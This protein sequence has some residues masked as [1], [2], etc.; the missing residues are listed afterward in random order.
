MLASPVSIR[1]AALWAAIGQSVVLL[2]TIG[3]LFVFTSAF[4]AGVHPTTQSTILTV[5]RILAAAGLFGFYYFLWTDEGRLPGGPRCRL[6]ARVAAGALLVMY[7][8][9]FWQTGPRL[10]TYGLI[11]TLAGFALIALL[12]AVAVGSVQFSQTAGLL[13]LDRK[14]VV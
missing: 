4:T 2:T 13:T 5:C 1:Q 14:S 10:F 3:D 9:S 12:Y 6:S 8:V 7:V 11:G